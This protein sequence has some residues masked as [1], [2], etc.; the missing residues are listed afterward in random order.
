MRRDIKLYFWNKCVTFSNTFILWKGPS[1]TLLTRQW[2]YVTAAFKTR[3]IEFE[4][5]RKHQG[6]AL[7]K[8][9]GCCGEGH[10]GSMT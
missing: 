4:G 6:D 10:F 3:A 9:L 1:P 5:S 7:A 8:M 2:L